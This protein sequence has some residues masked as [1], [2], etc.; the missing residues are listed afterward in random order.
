MNVS[1]IST[2]RQKHSSIITRLNQIHL[3]IGVFLKLVLRI[4]KENN[5]GQK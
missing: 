2:A 1:I 4:R 5:Q 3:H